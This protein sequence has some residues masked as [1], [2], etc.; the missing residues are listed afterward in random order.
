MG[1][2]GARKVAAALFRGE[3]LRCGS[4]YTDGESYF[5]FNNRIFVQGGFPSTEVEVRYRMLGYKC[6][7]TFFSFAGWVTQST[8]RHLKCCLGGSGNL[9]YI[10]RG[11]AYY[12][13]ASTA[14]ELNSNSWYCYDDLS[15]LARK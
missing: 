6:V 11:V 12:S 8:L 5:L 1:N 7:P 13:Y 15:Q 9:L 3:R 2:L 4:A 14:L 10:K